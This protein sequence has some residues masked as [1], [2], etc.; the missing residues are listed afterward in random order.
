MWLEKFGRLNLP[1]RILSTALPP[2]TIKSK[3]SPMNILSAPKSTMKFPVVLLWTALMALK[4][5]FKTIAAEV[6]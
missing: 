3:V 2:M 6:A 1:W 4:I 5:V